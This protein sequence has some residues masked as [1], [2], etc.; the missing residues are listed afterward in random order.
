MSA[1]GITSLP[2][3][4]AGLG[5]GV[6]GERVIGTKHSGPVGI[7]SVIEYR[8]SYPIYLNISSWV[9]TFIVVT[10]NGLDGADLRLNSQPNPGEHGETPGDP[11]FGGRTLV[12]SGK[13]YA[14]TIWKLRDMQQ[15]L[16]A[17]FMDIRHEYPL[18]FHAVDPADD[19]ML[20]CKLADKINIPDVQTVKNEHARDFQITLRASNPRF[21]SAVAERYIA[22]ALQA[23]IDF[24][25]VIYPVIEYFAV[26]TYGPSSGYTIGGFKHTTGSG[27]LLP[28]AIQR[29]MVY[30]PKATVDL[31]SITSVR[32]ETGTAATIQRATPGIPFGT[33]VNVTIPA[34][35][36]TYTGVRF[37]NASLDIN[38]ATRVVYGGERLRV[39]GWLQQTTTAIANAGYGLRINWRVG[40]P[41]LASAPAAVPYTDAGFVIRDPAVTPTVGRWIRINTTVDV[42]LGQAAYPEVEIY[43]AKLDGSALGAG[44]QWQIAEM[45]LDFDRGTAS[46]PYGDGNTPGWMWETATAYQYPSRRWMPMANM[47]LNP[48]ANAGG[49]SVAQLGATPY[50][51]PPGQSPAQPY[52]GHTT[53]WQMTV[54]SNSVSLVDLTYNGQAPI[55]HGVR[56]DSSARVDEGAT[57]NLSFYMRATTVARRVMY[58]AQF[59]APPGNP[60]VANKYGNPNQDQGTD[61]KDA[62]GTWRRFWVDITVPPGQIGMS[63]AIMVASDAA[64]TNLPLDEM[65]EISAIM[66]RPG[67]GP[68]RFVD[69]RGTIRGLPAP[70]YSWAGTANQS[71][72][73]GPIADRNML[74]DP[75]SATATAI[76]RTGI[77]AVVSKVA[78]GTGAG[79]STNFY[80][81]TYGSAVSQFSITTQMGMSVESYASERARHSVSTFVR[82]PPG[83]TYSRKVVLEIDWFDRVGSTPNTVLDLT[84]SVPINVADQWVEI[85]LEGISAPA[86]ANAAVVS[87]LLL[88]PL[89]GDILDVDR[90]MLTEADTIEQ[91]FGPRTEWA[92]PT[93]V[94]NPDGAALRY[95]QSTYKTQRTFTQVQQTLAVSPIATVA[96]KEDEIHMAL[97][98]LDQ[99]NQIYI[100][101]DSA[102]KLSI[103]KWDAGTFSKLMEV[104]IP[105]KTPQVSQWMRGR[106][107]DGVI[108]AEW[109]TASPYLGNLAVVGTKYTMTATEIAK[110]QTSA[111]PIALGIQN[112]GGLLGL[113][114]WRYQDVTK[115]DGWDYYEGAG[116]VTQSSGT[117]VPLDITRK[118]LVRKDITYL[119]SDAEVIIQHRFE[120][121]P[122]SNNY[123]TGILLKALDKDNWIA[124]FFTGLPQGS[125]A[126]ASGVLMK[127]DNGVE[128]VIDSATIGAS[129]PATTA[130]LRGVTS[131]NTITIQRWTADPALG[132]S[133]TSTGTIT[134][135]GANATKFGSGIKGRYGIFWDPNTMTASI[136]EYRITLPSFDDIAF[137]VTNKGNFDAQTTIELT[138]PMTNPTV[139]NEANSTA[140][141]ISGTIPAGETWVLEN[142]GPNKRFYRKSDGANRFQYLAA[143]SMWVMLKPNNVPNPIHLIATGL[144]KGWDVSMIYRHTFM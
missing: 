84:R 9:D 127:R 92:E 54:R 123:S 71:E 13:Q 6:S 5:T 56:F 66:L 52:T 59:T 96:G 28:R 43:T 35:S 34:S 27:M 137:T 117:L 38:S 122:T 131:G 101:L 68:R 58:L 86:K 48:T 129:A 83:T 70:E 113:S 23:T 29:N 73:L 8:S 47:I 104:T 103:C 118:I 45:M 7:E 25:E 108:F 65:H 75:D 63:V 49:G 121:R 124:F 18:I 126:T 4:I 128:S 14:K 30:N 57:Y 130:W 37:N 55:A 10:I 32:G 80:R 141:I 142:N 53:W 89:A 85:K 50:D 21:L 31:T 93:D 33:A 15:A 16:R 82:L 98:Y 61:G 51:A 64:D 3:V 114:E 19:L 1:Y 97:S 17:A 125:G 99:E 132:G 26:S 94:A 41:T 133:P 120:A 136:D 40:S 22:M 139:L 67:A 79:A 69:A 135:T 107:K 119:A 77:N 88:D 20:M 102:N 72:S 138:G 91:W 110:F 81:A 109:Y 78:N 100:R 60:I 36:S 74:S 140:A 115:P 2:G 87:A 144:A 116:T 24:N 62:V 105:A 106:M 76:L 143:T 12:L 112:R 44:T 90:M 111:Y 11:L 134:L 39:T 46:A 95:F 42:P